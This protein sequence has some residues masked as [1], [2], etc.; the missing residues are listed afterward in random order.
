LAPLATWELFRR[1]MTV[2]P[3][4]G[5][6]LS[7]SPATGVVSEQGEVHGYPGLHVAD[8]S[9]IPAAIGFHPCM[10]VSAV[11]ELVAESIA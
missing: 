9:V 6:H 1:I 3:L 2:H 5:C 4:G 10:T 8:G 11:A 7:A